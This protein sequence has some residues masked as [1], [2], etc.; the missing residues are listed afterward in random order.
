MYDVAVVGLGPVG[1]LATLL[2]AG[3][4]LRV[5]ALDREADVYS[6]PRVGVLDS[7]ALR[8]LQKAGVYDRASADIILGAGAQW[9]SRHGQTL[10]TTMPTESLH[11]HPWLSAIYQPLLDRTLREAL[12]G[13]PGVDIR[14]QHTLTALTDTGDSM[15]LTFRGP[16][17]VVDTAHARF[18]IGC[19]GANSMT[20]ACIGVD[21]VGSTY[22]E[23]WLVV[24][25]KLPEP[26]A[27]IPYF[28]FTMDPDGPRMT[29][30]LAAGNHRWERMVMPGEDREE[31][32]TLATARA[33]IAEH[34][35]PDTV[36]ILRHVIYTHR[37]KQAARWRAGRVLLCGDAAHLMPPMAG[38][39]L[40]SGIRDVTNLTW[41]L[42]AVIKAD[43]PQTLLDSYE[44][45]R[46]PHVEHMT[47]LAINLGRLLMM[48]SRS[49]AAVRDATI[50]AL[51]RVRPLRRAVLQGRY[52]QPA[53]YTDGLLVKVPRR[54]A[55][56]R[57]FPQ[58][59]VR[60]W[61]GA[62]HRLDDLT[63][64]GWRI[65]G[66][67]ADPASALSPHAQ[68]LTRELLSAHLTTLCGP[69]RRPIEIGASRDVLEDTEEITRPVFGGRPFVVVRPDGYVYA[70]PTEKELDATIT[71][72]VPQVVGTAKR[73]TPQPLPAARNTAPKEKSKA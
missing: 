44:I 5:L 69:G 51:M 31:I 10:A 59:A 34:V 32:S 13:D 38:Q 72:L 17:G 19:D 64:T 53:H 71:G 21:M 33:M 41:K 11:G 9:A 2:L 18:V 47:T 24:D 22:E 14:L 42:A 58:P 48:R 62:V 1:E 57:L 26:L 50:R 70:N 68:Q 25:T 23:P 20:R 12:T 40:N 29:G 46:R 54:P 4:G 3:E 30:R 16:D 66:W 45:E 73:S 7:E 60:T 65:I 39:G 52:R 35:D 15:A 63:G 6:S 37:A 67:E 36:E 43:A 55:V 8:T 56:G 61:A 49:G 28:R 27:C